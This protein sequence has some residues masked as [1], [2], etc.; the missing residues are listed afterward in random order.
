MS[1]LK[2]TIPWATIMLG[3]LVAV[4]AIAGAVV[5]I[6]HGESLSFERYLDLMKSFAIAVGVLGIG[7]GIVSLGRSNAQAATLSDT[8]LLSSGPPTDEWRPTLGEVEEFGAP[9]ATNNAASES[10]TGTAVPPSHR[11]SEG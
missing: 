11:L 8:S 10:P 3:V 7:R 1:R 4:A 2:D 9:E 6:V 5:V